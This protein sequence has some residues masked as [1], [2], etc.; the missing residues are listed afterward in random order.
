VVIIPF[1]DWDLTPKSQSVLWV[2]SEEVPFETARAF[3]VKVGK[4]LQ[5]S[6]FKEEYIKEQQHI[7]VDNLNLLYVAFTR[8]EEHLY[9]ISRKPT[10][11]KLADT[12][13]IP[14][15]S[16]HLIYKTLQSDELLA[17]NLDEGN[18]VFEKGIISKP[19]RKTRKENG[20]SKNLQDWHSFSWKPRLKM[21]IS[22]RKISINDPDTPETR[23]GLLYHQLVSEI[24]SIVDPEVFVKTHSASSG[25]E[26]DMQQR[27]IREIKM[28]VDAANIHGWFGADSETVNEAELLLPDGSILRPDRL[29]LRDK[30]AIVIDYKTGVEEAYHEEQVVQYAKILKEMGYTETKI[31]LVYPAFNKVV[32]VTAA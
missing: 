23:Y 21:G 3:P 19:F 13:S 14:S 27:L 12:E 31:F 26:S 25:V 30:N 20:Q 6:V 1:A 8:A 32:E 29:I 2:A 9:V 28:F 24:S 11:K 16:G 17:V 5:L 4:D 18:G 15:K 10:A 22:K 7:Y